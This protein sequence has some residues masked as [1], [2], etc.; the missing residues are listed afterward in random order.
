MHYYFLTSHRLGFRHW[1]ADDFDSAQQLWG[2]PKVTEYTGKPLSAA[3]VYRRLYYEIKL[4]RS[5]SVQ[6]WPI[7]N[8]ITG[9]FIGCCGLHP[10]DIS[11]G[12]FEI[13][14]EVRSDLWG[15]GYGEE[16]L[17]AVIAWSKTNPAVKALFAAH[18]PEDDK[19]V[20]MADKLGFEDT[21]AQF[22][23]STGLHHPSYL[24]KH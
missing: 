16:A 13:A 21:H 7:F 11:K 24:L 3:R 5:H 4:Q 8:K 18:H 14:V 23:G 9:E 19:S 10:Y 20:R 17:A 1:H 6:N 15:E 12:V 2:D 22:Y